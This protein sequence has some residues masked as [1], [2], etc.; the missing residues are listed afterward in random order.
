MVKRSRKLVKKRPGSKRSVRKGRTSNRNSRKILKKR[1]VKRG[2]WPWTSKKTRLNKTEAI[3]NP[4]KRKSYLPWRG[5]VTSLKGTQKMLECMSEKKYSDTPL[6]NNIS[7]K[8]S[9]CEELVRKETP[10]LAR[11]QEKMDVLPLIDAITKNGEISKNHILTIRKKLLVPHYTSK[12][13]GPGTIKTMSQNV[14]V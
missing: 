13:Q 7:I 5:R 6:S 11:K 12:L 8:K 10:Y 3:L 1:S 2:G 4:T 14:R 9:Q